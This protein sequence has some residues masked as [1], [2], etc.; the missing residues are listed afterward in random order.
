MKR[1]QTAG[2]E[3]IILL[4]DTACGIYAAPSNP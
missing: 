3:A 1:A 2:A 4:F